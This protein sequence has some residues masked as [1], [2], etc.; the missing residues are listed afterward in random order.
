MIQENKG[1]REKHFYLGF[2]IILIGRCQNLLN[3]NNNLIK[4]KFSLVYYV[5]VGDQK[6]SKPGI[7][8]LENPEEEI[9]PKLSLCII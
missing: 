3:K 1:R 4:R 9:L 5:S 2:S 8:K 6:S 7:F